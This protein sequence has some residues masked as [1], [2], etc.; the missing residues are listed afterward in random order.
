MGISEDLSATGIAVQ[1]GYLDAAQVRALSDCLQ[2]RRQRG[3]FA[4]GR[5]GRDATLQKNP[6]VRGDRTCWLCEPL[7]AAEREL[8]AALEQ[9][10]M[11]L[12]REL[13]LGLFELELH[14]A[15][16]PPG[17]GYARHVDQPRGSAARLMSIILYLN[18]DWQTE[19]GG[20][21]ELYQGR[22]ERRRLEP[23]AGRL[24]CFLTGGREHAVLAAHRDRFSI[25]GWYR[26]RGDSL[27]RAADDAIDPS[28]PAWEPS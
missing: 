21:L 1:D 12:N 17:A 25:S 15:W 10:R 19:A 20:E 22:G 28:T 24:V 9:L 16:Y 23:Q 3:D 18:E 13:Y 8:L 27:R 5:I 26:A 14:Y 7:F 4:E 11:Q 6:A 2:Q